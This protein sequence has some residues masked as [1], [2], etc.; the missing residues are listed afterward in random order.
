MEVRKT[1]LP[2]LHSQLIEKLLHC[3]HMVIK[4]EYIWKQ[5]VHLMN[6]YPFILVLVPIWK[7]HIQDSQNV[8]LSFSPV[9]W[10]ISQ[11]QC[12][13]ETNLKYV[14]RGSH[15]RISQ[16]PIQSLVKTFGRSKSYQFATSLEVH[17]NCR[18]EYCCQMTLTSQAQGQN[19][20]SHSNTKRNTCLSTY[21][22]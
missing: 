2:A 21:W 17:N 6:W 4:Y 12:D 5:P 15:P 20:V 3:S 9:N 16:I 22:E 8:Q 14:L 7:L 1:L 11:S 13:D 18:E 19:Q 10:Q